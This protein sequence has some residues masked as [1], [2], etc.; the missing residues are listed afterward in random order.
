[1]VLESERHGIARLPIPIFRGA[2]TTIVKSKRHPL[3]PTLN[4]AD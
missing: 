3:N 4:P 1:M 2:Y